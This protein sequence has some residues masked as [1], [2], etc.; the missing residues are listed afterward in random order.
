MKKIAYLVVL[1]TTFT[2]VSCSGSEEQSNE[3]T[4]ETTVSEEK[5]NELNDAQELQQE[6][7]TLEEDLNQFLDSL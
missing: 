1:L 3:E 2:F 5:L 6:A 7:E 4:V